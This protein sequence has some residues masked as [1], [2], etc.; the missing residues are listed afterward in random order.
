MACKPGSV[1]LAGGRPSIST[2]D[3]SGA[4]AVNPEVP[5]VR[6]SSRKRL[7]CLPIRPCS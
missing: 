7:E 1:P 3:C 2:P 5:A 4:L 6:R